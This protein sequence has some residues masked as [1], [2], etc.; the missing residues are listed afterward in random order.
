MEKRQLQEDRKSFMAGTLGGRTS[1]TL[2]GPAPSLRCLNWLTALGLERLA[3]RARC[4][5]GADRC[6][7]HHKERSAASLAHS[8]RGCDQRRHV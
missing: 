7:H 6:L 2:Q 8:P 5:G 3:S 4:I 1:A